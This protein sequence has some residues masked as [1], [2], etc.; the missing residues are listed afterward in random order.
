MLLCLSTLSQFLALLLAFDQVLGHQPG[1]L[2]LEAMTILLRR[3]GMPPGELGRGATDVLPAPGVLV[4]AIQGR[5]DR[6][7]LPWRQEWRSRLLSRTAE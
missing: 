4:V 7:E 1:P 3:V 5:P 6:S 2:F